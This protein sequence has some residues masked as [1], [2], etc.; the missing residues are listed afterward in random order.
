[1]NSANLWLLLLPAVHFHRFYQ[2]HLQIQNGNAIDL[3]SPDRNQRSFDEMKLFSPGYPGEPGGPSWPF[4]PLLPGKPLNPR[5]PGIPDQ[6][7]WP[8]IC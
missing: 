1:M 5:L 7:V 3:K 4:S 2:R 8:E 6:P